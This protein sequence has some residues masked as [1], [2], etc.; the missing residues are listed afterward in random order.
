[1]SLLY[2]KLKNA[3]E[4]QSVTFDGS[5]IQIGDVKRLVAEKQGLG[6]DGYQEITLYDPNTGTEYDDDGKVVPRNTLVEVKRTPAAT[7]APLGSA[8]AGVVDKKQEEQGGTMGE[9]ESQ[10]LQNLMQGTASTWQKE[11]RQGVARGRGRGKGTVPAEYRC[12]RCEAYGAH[13]IQDCP[14][15]GDPTYDR[16]RVRPPVGIPMTRLARSMEGGLVLPDGNTGTLVANEEAFAKEVL[17]IGAMHHYPTVAGEETLALEGPEQ[18]QVEEDAGEKPASAPV[19]FAGLPFSISAMAEPPKLAG[20]SLKLDL[21]GTT[22]SVQKKD[23]AFF[24]LLKNPELPKG[25]KNFLLKAYDRDSPLS[26]RE[27]EREQRHYRKD[28]DGASRSPSRH[29]RERRERSPSR[30]RSRSSSRRRSHRDS[31]SR[32]RERRR[33]HSPRDGGKRSPRKRTREDMD[34]SV[35]PEDS[36]IDTRKVSDEQQQTKSDEKMTDVDKKHSPIRWVPS[37]P[38]REGMA[39]AGQEEEPEID[40][41]ASEDEADAQEFQKKEEE[42]KRSRRGHADERKESKPASTRRDRQPRES[43]RDRK[44]DRRNNDRSRRSRKR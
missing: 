28:R 26:R 29:R 5:V 24:D 18:Q 37:A 40:Y 7:F 35:K 27:F 43:D 42:S 17:G 33:S 1:M 19:A 8:A 3:I 6:P 44:S 41:G 32:R 10:A 16:K 14:T 9:D 13:W 36:T 12:P 2:F 11:V 25:P 20:M 21:N 15:H 30:R 31:S 4:Q 22:D 38:A 39:P 34:V 23:D